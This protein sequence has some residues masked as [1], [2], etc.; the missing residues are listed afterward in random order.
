[1]NP[2]ERESRKEEILTVPWLGFEHNIANCNPVA[3]VEYPLLRGW[4]T[5]E[6]QQL[7]DGELRHRHPNGVL[8][9]VQSWMFLGLLEAFFEESF[10]SNDF[11]IS[12]ADGTAI[13]TSYLREFLDGYHFSMEDHSMSVIELRAR[14]QTIVGTLREA[15]FWNQRLIELNS[16]VGGP[17]PF[18]NV[19]LF[20][21]VMRLITLVAEALWTLADRFP[22]PDHRFF[23]NCDWGISSGNDSDLRARIQSRGWC[24]TLFDKFKNLLRTPT[25]F[26]E[27][28]SLVS[29]FQES[30]KGHEG[31]LSSSR[32]IEYNIDESRYKTKHINDCNCMSIKPP[33][34]A[35]K[36]AL[37]QWTI[38]LMNGD[39]LL[40][41]NATHLATYSFEDK[42]YFV[43]FS[44]VWSDGLASNTEEGLPE[45][46]IRYL[47][48]TAQKVANTSLFWIDS[49]C[50]PKDRQTRKLAISMMVETY[51]S[52]SATVVLDSGIRRCTQGMSLETI[53]VAL[54]LSMWQQRLWTLQESSL[55]R[56]IY[57][58][59]EDAL[60]SRD[61]ILD[62]T[63]QNLHRPIIRSGHLFLDNL[64]GWAHTNQVTVGGL[65]RNLYC[66]TSTKLDDE[67]L[68][69]A[70][71]LNVDVSSL[72]EVN[73]EAR[74]IR[75]WSMVKNVPKDIIIHNAP[76]ISQDGYRWAPRSIMS[77]NTMVMDFQDNSALVTTD[78]L[79]GMFLV[80]SFDIT[81]PLDLADRNPMYDPDSDGL[82]VVGGAIQAPDNFP[83]SLSRNQVIALPGP[84]GS[85]IIEEKIGVILSLLSDGASSLSQD[86]SVCMY[87]G[88][89]QVGMVPKTTFFSGPRVLPNGNIISPETAWAEFARHLRDRGMI[90]RG[91]WREIII[92]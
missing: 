85:S 40:N 17:T 80:Y 71:F 72:Q 9:M 76:K 87:E 28:V 58:Q 70:P 74:M 7:K 46:Q 27:Y 65:Q 10:D 73:G 18:A 42:P 6:I 66:R 92:R 19:E 68:A 38:P 4:T 91:T 50:I 5:Q 89:V 33:L 43:A 69:V 14:Q 83:R 32:C 12:G 3:L 52:A 24:P 2:S 31:C 54:T 90:G 30:P 61:T 35:V 36:N 64:T 37:L 78:G 59:F 20:D 63:S 88:L 8:A 39:D 82:L 79:K 44:H 45:C 25:S 23:I 13:D 55:S 47:R 15:A 86:I 11:I 48:D 56:H 77:Q 1:M 81:A 22:S 62:E 53:I 60:V 67:A 51:R 21:P 41:S 57:F 26:L 16:Q 75:F 34:E 49:L 84:L 29:P